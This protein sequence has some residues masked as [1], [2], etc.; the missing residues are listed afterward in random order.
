MGAWLYHSSVRTVRLLAVVLWAGLI[1]FLSSLSD[2]P[3]TTSAEWPSNLAH[4]VLFGVLALLILRV[5][6]AWSQDRPLLPLAL[7]AWLLAVAYGVS[8][9]WHQSFVPNRDVSAL[10]A[11]FDA[12]GAAIALIIVLVIWG[13][14]S[15]DAPFPR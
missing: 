1:F 11:A 4:M 2:P 12:L 5:L 10:D 8:D 9:E 13:A 15:H 14:E 6:R 7:V 3:G